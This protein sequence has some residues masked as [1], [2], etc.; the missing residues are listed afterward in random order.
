MA[1]SGLLVRPVPA[2][3]ASICV[4]LLLATSAYAGK[5]AVVAV[6]RGASVNNVQLKATVSPPA[7]VTKPVQT[8][9]MSSS[10][11]KP[12]PA[13]DAMRIAPA[14]QPSLLPVL[15]DDQKKAMA[16]ETREDRRMSEHAKQL[17]LNAKGAKL[18]QDNASIQ[19]G[20][21]E[22]KE[23]AGNAMDAASVEMAFGIASGASGIA[24]AAGPASTAQ[25]V[26]T[27]PKKLVGK[28]CTPINPC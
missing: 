27:A 12:P 17:E 11:A 24:P 18:K 25:P 13:I 4:A 2:S 15:I 19:A 5:E 14:T 1:L 6:P 8:Q 9:P 21:D 7:A 26:T 10:I 3:A 16:K 23:K 22:A 20:M 28:P